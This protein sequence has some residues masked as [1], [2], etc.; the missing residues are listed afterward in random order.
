MNP[1]EKTLSEIKFVRQEH[2]WRHHT[3]DE[4]LLQYEYMKNGNQEAI[5]LSI[6]LFQG[7]TTGT[8]SE[9]PLRNYKY[10]FVASITLCC[11]FC[12]EGGMFSEDAYD[13]SD[14]Y[15][16]MADKCR[17]VEEVFALHTRM[18]TDY[19]QRMAGLHKESVFS[20]PILQCVDYIDLHL[21]EHM[22][23]KSLAQQVHLSPAYLSTLFAREVGSPVSGY[24]RKK[25]LEAAKILLQYSD[26]SCVEIANYLA[27]SSHSHF[28]RLFKEYTGFTPKQYRLQY[29]RHN[30]NDRAGKSD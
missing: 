11:R 27:F 8:L 10:L 2:S 13:L 20:K 3:Y 6:R 22:T 15:I 9:D 28:N 1:M 19:T 7:N 30:W 14:L 26:Y 16:R 18:F 23:V 4:E 29:F 5:P 12:M 17:S 21:H 24:I 25:R